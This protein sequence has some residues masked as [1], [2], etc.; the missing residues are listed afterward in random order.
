MSSEAPPLTRVDWP[1]THRIIRSRFPPIDLFEDIADPADWDAIA[2]AE[3]KTNPRLA[4]SIGLLDLV[5]P[6]RRVSGEGATWLMAPFVHV[7]PDRSSR[8][9]DGSYG[10]YYA[11]DRFEVALFETIHHHGRFMAATAQ[12]PGWTSDFRELVGAIDRELHDLRESATWS[13]CLDPD[14]Y[15]PP[16]ALGTRLRADGSNGLVYPS[17]R[18]PKG[19]CIAVFWPDL[20]TIPLQARHLSYH[21]DG[22][23]IDRIRDLG[24]GEVFAVEG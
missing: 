15:G 20:M 17:V 14:D 9:S 13:D 24:S 4:E 16:Q 1:K 11:G 5:P 21:W 23:R 6:A 3:S 8:F 12:A 22:S 19:A 2:S 18:Y 7:S 10:V